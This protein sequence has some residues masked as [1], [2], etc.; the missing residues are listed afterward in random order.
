MGIYRK[1]NNVL[2]RR[3]PVNTVRSRAPRAIASITYDDFP[4]SAWTVAG[5]I[6][7]KFGVRATYY[8]AGRFCGIT[9]DGIEY[10][11][12]TDLKAVAAAGHEIGCH[13]YSHGFAS[14]TD[15][16]TLL[17]EIERNAAFLRKH[18]G[19]IAIDSYAYPYGDVSPRTKT[20]LGGAFK[21]AR[22][23]SRRVNTGMIDLAM[24]HSIVL[25]H[26]RWRPDEIEASIAR[27]KAS[28]GWI[29]FFTHDVGAAPLDFGV[30]PER[31]E[32]VLQRI[33]DHGIEILPV[34]EAVDLIVNG[35]RQ[36]AAAA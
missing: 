15:S 25:E 18:L 11:D 3:L 20:L 13:S 21:S 31:L 26:R 8:V 22:G 17:H 7:A 9:E 35:E 33:A 23:I 14:K 16:G 30:L 1:V 28:G 2:T 32:W 6:M 5:P 29:T 24:V 34:N 4:K 10:F 36:Q 27:A 19:D 12:L